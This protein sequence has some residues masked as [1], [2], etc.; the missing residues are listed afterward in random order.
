M[1]FYGTK[2]LLTRPLR[3]HRFLRFSRLSWQTREPCP[4]S[5]CVCSCLVACHTRRQAVRLAAKPGCVA[6]SLTRVLVGSLVLLCASSACNARLT[7]QCPP[8]DAAQRSHD[9]LSRFCHCIPLHRA[10][11]DR[12]AASARAARPSASASSPPCCCVPRPHCPAEDVAA[13]HGRRRQRP[14]RTGEP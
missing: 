1:L 13:T 9:V 12:E 4:R 2:T 8:L 10:A 11:S 3:G 14:R 7:P 5:S 6:L